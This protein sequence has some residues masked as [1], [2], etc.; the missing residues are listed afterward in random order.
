MLQLRVNHGSEFFCSDCKAIIKRGEYYFYDS[1][2]EQRYC[3]NCVEI[4]D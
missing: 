4:I 2:A 3:I 1:E